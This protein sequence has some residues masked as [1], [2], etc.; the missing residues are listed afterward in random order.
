MTREDKIRLRHMTDAAREAASFAAGRT[1]W[2]LDDDRQLVM[3]LVDAE[4]ARK[5][6]QARTDR[7]H[8]DKTGVVRVGG[9]ERR[10]AALQRYRPAFQ[11]AR[12]SSL[13]FP[14]A[15]SANR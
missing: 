14:T 7:I 2:D 12:A 9:L 1:R 11:P 10:G 5:T 4:R 3:A 6:P 15:G 8:G 13:L